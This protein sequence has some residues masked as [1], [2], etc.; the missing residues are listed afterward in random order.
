MFLARH[1]RTGNKKYNKGPPFISV[2]VTNKKILFIQQ[3]GM[4]DPGAIKKLKPGCLLLVALGISGAENTMCFLF[5]VLKS[6]VH[7]CLNSEC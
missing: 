2:K 3:K 7:I 1:Q 6:R 4:K 5:F